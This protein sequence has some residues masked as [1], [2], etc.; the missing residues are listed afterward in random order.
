MRGFLLKTMRLC[1]ALAA[2]ILVL[3]GPVSAKDE[4]KSSGGFSGASSPPKPAA[5]VSAPK[6]PPA[7]APAAAS[8][9]PT[10]GGFMGATQPKPP[11][12]SGGFMSGSAK[13]DAKPDA[14]P[15]FKP[16]AGKPS[17]PQVSTMQ[18]ASA[19]DTHVAR[20][21]AAKVSE[22]RAT[23]AFK[24]AVGDRTFTAQQ[25]QDSRAE[26]YRR[27]ARE[28]EREASA[29]YPPPRD[30]RPSYGSFSSGFL[31]G[32]VLNNAAFAHN[33]SD[34]PSYRQWRRDADERAMN[35]ERLRSQLDELDRKVAEMKDKP[36][37]PNF[38]P[39]DVPPEVIYSDDV[40]TN[41]A[42]GSS[43]WVRWLLGIVLGLA[44]GGFAVTIFLN[45]NRRRLA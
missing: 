31:W 5:T 38:V 44:V 28:R 27:V 41:S 13:P 14:R 37:D 15:D 23:P 33:H 8:K 30:G 16:E 35:D 32:M 22:T 2:A 4:H 29:Y 39:K 7:P 11:A 26:Y 12:A 40:L 21:N 9:P 10:S 1:A 25:I 6:P 18:R 20:E 24:D 45:A 17:V 42:G 43:H 3:A 34:D 19:Y 36:K